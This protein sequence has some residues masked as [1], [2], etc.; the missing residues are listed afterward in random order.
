MT[1]HTALRV[2]ATNTTAKFPVNQTTDDKVMLRKKNWMPHTRTPKH[3]PRPP[4]PPY[5]MDDPIMSRI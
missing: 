5:T 1:S 4:I 3:N 2:I